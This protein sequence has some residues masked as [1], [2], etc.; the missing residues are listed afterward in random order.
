[1]KIPESLASYLLKFP[2][3]EAFVEWLIVPP[4]SEEACEQYPELFGSSLCQDDRQCIQP[5]VSRLAFYMIL[6][7]TGESH[8]MAESLASQRCAIG[9]TDDIFFAGMGMLGDD[10]RPQQLDSLIKTAKSQG[11]TPTANHVYMPGLAR[12]RGD[13]EAFV[14]RSDGRTY[15]K[16]LLE[17]RGWEADGGVN[18]KGREPDRDP[19]DAAPA[20]ADDII[21]DSARDMIKKNPDLGKLSRAELRHK[22]VEKHGFKIGS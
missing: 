7:M 22:V 6:R 13:R 16:K 9:M 2:S 19:F 11:F 10:M 5:G 8:R 12:F 21:A 20:L 15:I 3:H 17:S 1:M 18:V 14:S 4:T